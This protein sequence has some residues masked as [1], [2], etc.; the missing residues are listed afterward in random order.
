MDLT[1]EAHVQAVHA[2]SGRTSVPSTTGTATSQLLASLSRSCPQLA[3]L[4]LVSSGHR[5]APY[6]HM[7]HCLRGMRCLTVLRLSGCDTG[8]GSSFDLDLSALL[9]LLTLRLDYL[10]LSRT[11]R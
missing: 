3:S 6:S 7:L 2:G 9:D 1:V 10:D 4:S 8:Y 5:L 11:A